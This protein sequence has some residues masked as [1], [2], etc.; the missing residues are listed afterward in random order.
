MPTHAR[1]P[2]SRRGPSSVTRS[3]PASTAHWNRASGGAWEAAKSTRSTASSPTTTAPRT[4]L[5]VTNG[6]HALELALQ[7]LGVGPGTEV[8]VPAFTFI[9]SSQAAQRLGAVAVPVDVTPDTYCIDLAATEAAITPPTRAIMPV[10]MAGHFADMDA[11]AKLSEASG[12]PL[13]QDAAHAH[14]A[15][16]GASGSASWR[17]WPR[18]A[19][20]T[21]S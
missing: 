20:R 5:A 13:I 15:S 17:P 14:G 18:S 12:V 19:S 3:G 21:A 1:F 7:V 16:G 11:L 4:S 2:N 6:T 8:I 9:S 10:H